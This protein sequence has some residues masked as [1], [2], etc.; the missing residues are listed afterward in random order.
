M[1]P[2]DLFDVD[3]ELEESFEEIR[4]RVRRIRTGR[5]FLELHRLDGVTVEHRVL[6]DRTTERDLE[7][8]MQQPPQPR[9]A[10]CRR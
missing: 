3:V 2:R 8:L 10:R 9:E 6:E 4:R 1:K 7:R 5:V